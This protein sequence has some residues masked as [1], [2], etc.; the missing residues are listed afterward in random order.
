MNGYLAEKNSKYYAVISYKDNYGNWKS[1][2]IATGLS[3]KNNK[4]KAQEF[5]QIKLNEME[6]TYNQKSTFDFNVID[7]D[8]KFT[9]YINK[10]L[11]KEKSTGRVSEITF[12][13]YESMCKNH[14]IPFFAA[15]DPFL[16]EIDTEMLQAFIDHERFSGN[17]SLSEKKKGQGLSSKSLKH[18]KTIL[19]LIFK[20]ARRE[21]L[22]RE[23]PCEFLILPKQTKRDITFFDSDELNE[24]FEKI[25]D[26]ELFPLIY[27]TVFYGLRKSEVLGLKWDSIDFRRKTVTIKHTVVKYSGIIEKDS[28]KTDSSYRVYP[29]SPEIEEIFKSQKQKELES[30]KKY[31]KSYICNDYIFKQDCGMMYRPDSLT[32][33]FSRILDRYDMPHIRFHDLRH[34]CAS[35][36][37]SQ[38][39]QLKDVQEWLGHADISTT[40]NIYAHLDQS[41]KINIMNAMQNIDKNR[42]EE[43]DE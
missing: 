7:N 11:D 42:K 5:L 31:G 9:S 33:S 4:R 27:V 21:R 39:Y 29:L 1:K 13:M 17:L 2:W 16:K 22:V 23:N 28:T 20:E 32:R 37:I 30:K 38:G 26:E 25:R 6:E 36:L 19:N 8:I 18:L 3:T 12:G 10:W 14:I 41:R 34:S 15:F 35:L 40:A 24:L 43:F